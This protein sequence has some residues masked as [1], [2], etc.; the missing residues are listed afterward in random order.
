MEMFELWTELGR[1]LGRWVS[2]REWHCGRQGL[3]KIIIINYKF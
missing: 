2:V 3:W 1:L